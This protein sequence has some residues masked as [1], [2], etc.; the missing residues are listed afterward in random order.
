MES[1]A[2]HLSKKFALCGEPNPEKMLSGS[3]KDGGRRGG[4]PKNF[5]LSVSLSRRKFRSFFSLWGSPRGILGSE[6]RS[7]GASPDGQPLPALFPPS[8]GRGW[9]INGK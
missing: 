9:V 8:A 4:G 2:T 5:A 6:V 1:C 3:A 7:L